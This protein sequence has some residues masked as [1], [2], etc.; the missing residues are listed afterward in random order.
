MHFAMD[1]FL[2]KASSSTFSMQVHPSVPESRCEQHLMPAPQLSVQ[3]G[4]AWE[5]VIYNII[6]KVIT[7]LINLPAAD[8]IW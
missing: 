2:K 3:C 8:N 1:S 4:D 7:K 5:Y 6:L